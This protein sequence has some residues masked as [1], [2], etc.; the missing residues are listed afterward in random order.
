MEVTTEFR[1]VTQDTEANGESDQLLTVTG[2]NLCMEGKKH[3]EKHGNDEDRELMEMENDEDE[4]S[5]GKRANTEENEES[6]AKL[7]KLGTPARERGEKQR[8][9][10]TQ[11][12]LI[13]GFLVN[14]AE[15]VTQETK[16]KTPK[17]LLMKMKK[18]TNK[19]DGTVKGNRF[20]LLLGDESGSETDITPGIDQLRV[21][22]GARTELESEDSTQ[23]G[24]EVKQNIGVT[25]IK[26]M[27]TNDTE[28]SNNNMNEDR[29]EKRT[30]DE[31]FLRAD[32]PLYN[33]TNEFDVAITTE[34][35]KYIL[36]PIR[37]W[38]EMMRQVTDEKMNI[39]E[40]A[41]QTHFRLGIKAI[42]GQEEATPDEGWSGY[43]ALLQAK[44]MNEGRTKQDAMICADIRN[45]EFRNELVKYIRKIANEH[46][47]MLIAAEVLERMEDKTEALR[48]SKQY[49]VGMELSA[50]AGRVSWF[51][52]EADILW[53]QTTTSGEYAMGLSVQD[54]ET[55]LNTAKIGIAGARH[56]IL[57]GPS[58]FE[59]GLANLL[60]EHF[61]D[62]MN[63][64]S[65]IGKAA[66][67]AQ[68]GATQRR[69]IELLSEEGQKV[70]T[71]I[72]ICNIP[73][74]MKR[75]TNKWQKDM[76]YALRLFPEVKIK[77]K[78]LYTAMQT[79]V[80]TIDNNN[81]FGI[82]CKCESM[83]VGTGAFPVHFAM[84]GDDREILEGERPKHIEHK[85]KTRY[86][87]Q[88]LT[89]DEAKALPKAM[90]QCF[91][92]GCS[93]EHEIT[94]FMRI[95]VSKYLSSVPLE[96]LLTVQM[97]RHKI[98]AGPFVNETVVVVHA[99]GDNVE[100]QV[101]EGN[102]AL[103]IYGDRYMKQIEYGGLNFELV[104]GHVGVRGHVPQYVFKPHKATILVG[105]P[106]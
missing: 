30:E 11:Q 53:L 78:D 94:N 85:V 101:R 100:N 87:A 47:E 6:T 54:V 59:G 70:A 79:Y 3:G 22:G 69:R 68:S 5:L 90:T 71:R 13:S 64:A 61:T 31:I 4:N 93:D 50:R 96:R 73:I 106:K 41:L 48:K 80:D 19:K 58:L 46:R 82:L 74:A 21:N 63:N 72:F 83:M 66:Q 52:R 95:V 98:D 20:K 27:A 103:G 38:R 23:N 16:E 10:K 77:S 86:L 42:T 15:N 104:A 92:R 75:A 43:A 8:E 51:Q 1:V 7:T 35:V 33:L 84:I 24:K 2:R 14:K 49:H 102:K 62:V 34:G 55:V 65:D 56:F 44:W 32:D 99:I 67:R 89:E 29:E 97:K 60:E 25:N 17:P 36:R 18:T 105:F 57:G 45:S 76:E 91:F 40:A 88:L 81:T 26:L 28:M 12:S 9:K 37:R 39:K